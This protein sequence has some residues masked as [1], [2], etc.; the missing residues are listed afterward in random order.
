VS[1]VEGQEHVGMRMEGCLQ[2][3]QILGV[4]PVLGRSGDRGWIG[5]K[6]GWDR[7]IYEV[8][9]PVKAGGGQVG[10]LPHQGPPGFR[11]DG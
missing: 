8:N 5:L 1:E 6:C 2:Y 4:R 10:P 7:G 9:Q 11:E 3:V